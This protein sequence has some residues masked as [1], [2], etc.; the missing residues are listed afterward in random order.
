MGHDTTPP[1]LDHPTK[2]HRSISEAVKDQL[3][4]DFANRK[5]KDHTCHQILNL[6]P[7]LY[8]GP[9]K[10]YRKA[11][12]NRYWY[13]RDQY[14]NDRQNFNKILNEAEDRAAAAKFDETRGEDPALMKS[15]NT[16]TTWMS[17]PPREQATKQADKS[18]TPPVRTSTTPL[19]SSTT[20]TPVKLPPG[21][22]STSKTT[23]VKKMNVEDQPGNKLNQYPV[24][25]K[26]PPEF[27]SI[28]E[29]I[30]YCD[31][32]LFID[33]D[34]PE[35]NPH[36]LFVQLIKD[37]K[38]EDKKLIS[39]VKVW[40]MNI[41][42]F[43]DVVTYKF[44]D[45]VLQGRALM[46]YKPSVPYFFLKEQADLQAKEQIVCEASNN[47]MDVALTSID[48]DKSPW[49]TSILIIFPEDHVCQPD[50]K[51]D[52]API[53]NV[54]IKL[55][56]RATGT[57]QRFYP[58]FHELRS[59]HNFQRLRKDSFEEEEDEL[60]DMFAGMVMDMND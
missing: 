38:L 46:V 4:F 39:K 16:R 56:M 23:P 40:W 42:D 44:G 30:D 24:L 32:H 29:A 27:K 21:P 19:P 58:G 28:K 45:L 12:R 18:R 13:I 25:P 31:Y 6:R 17:S 52:I 5:H 26:N 55:K 15:S 33:F 37:V 36:G 51:S 22:T 35:G 34:F 8:I 2:D 48:L 10:V 47:S 43:H 41:G 60:A 3:L 7:E 57:H 53:A 9:N 20:T 50:L 14:R 59:V 49:T 54:R 11:S 1:D